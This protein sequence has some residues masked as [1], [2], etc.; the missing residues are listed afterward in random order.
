MTRAIG[1]M[2][3]NWH[4]RW[5]DTDRVS[6]QPSQKLVEM[7]RKC[8]VIHDAIGIGAYDDWA[9]AGPDGNDAF[10]AYV[11]E[12]YTEVAHDLDDAETQAT[13]RSDYPL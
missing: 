1:V 5:N 8:Q 6:A 4:N 13:R 11:D 2:N 7:L 3:G 9:D 10:A 12:K